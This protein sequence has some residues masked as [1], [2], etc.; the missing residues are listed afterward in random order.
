MDEGHKT[1]AA[2][3]ERN[4]ADA[5]RAGRIVYNR[6]RVRQTLLAAEYIAQV[7]RPLQRKRQ[8]PGHAG[9]VTAINLRISD[10]DRSYSGLVP[11]PADLEG[12]GEG[13]VGALEARLDG[14][15]D[16]RE[17]AVAI[18]DEARLRDSP[19]FDLAD[20]ALDAIEDLDI[21]LRETLTAIVK[22]AAPVPTSE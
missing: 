6:A 14:L 13:L 19:D 5:E 17:S 21:T 20:A 11:L 3:Q 10:A 22:S 15:T 16:L 2:I 8:A 18:A 4:E 1:L 12:S 9:R 7:W